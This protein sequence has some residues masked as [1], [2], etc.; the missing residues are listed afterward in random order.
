MSRELQ[1]RADII[2]KELKEALVPLRIE[3]RKMQNADNCEQF[4]VFKN[5][6][7]Q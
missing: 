7:P 4:K 1:E 5:A 6:A 2:T 3:I